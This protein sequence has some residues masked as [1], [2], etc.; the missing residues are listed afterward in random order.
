MVPSGRND[1]FVGHRRRRKVTLFSASLD[2]SFFG[3]RLVHDDVDEGK[4][5]CHRGHRLSFDSIFCFNCAV[6]SPEVS[7][8]SALLVVVLLEDWW[9]IFVRSLK[10]DRREKRKLIAFP[11]YMLQTDSRYL[12]HLHLACDTFTTTQHTSRVKIY[13]IFSHS[14]YYFEPFRWYSYLPVLCN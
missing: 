10:E 5:A 6:S 1:D 14:R 12:S 4:T 13:F 2:F 3:R 9:F 8:E 11:P 7:S